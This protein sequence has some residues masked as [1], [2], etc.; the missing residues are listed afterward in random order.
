MKALLF[1]ALATWLLGG[2]AWTTKGAEKHG[3]SWYQL[4]ER[5]KAKAA[6]TDEDYM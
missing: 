4:K 1:I 2:T 3:S 5:D 6:A